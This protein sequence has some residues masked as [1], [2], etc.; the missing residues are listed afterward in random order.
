[1]IAEVNY[2]ALYD[3]GLI[4]R[5]HGGQEANTP[6][7]WAASYICRGHLYCTLRSQ[8]AINRDCGE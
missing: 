2:L 3:S 8:V 6:R 7:S 4:G 1:M 5:V